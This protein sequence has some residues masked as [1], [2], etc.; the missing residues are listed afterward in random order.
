MQ[1]RPRGRDCAELGNG[2]EMALDCGGGLKRPRVDEQEGQREGVVVEMI[3]V[4]R[5]SV[6]PDELRQRL[7]TH[8]SL[9]GAIPTGALARGWRDLWK[10]RWAHR[11]SVEI[12]L[13]SR[14]APQR[15]LDSLAQEPRPLRR[16]DRFSL[17]VNIC[18][19]RSTDLRRFLDYAAECRVEELHVE[20][21]K[22]SVAEK[23]N[24]HLPL[25]SP[26]LAR[27][28]LRRISISNMYY[29]GAQQFHALE[30]VRLHFVSV[31]EATFCKMM[32][33]CP[34]LRTLDVRGCDCECLF[35]WTWKST[36]L[37]VNLRRI[38]VAECDG[39]AWLNLVPSLLSF[40]YY[41]S[42]F[43]A[44]RPSLFQRTPCSPTFTFA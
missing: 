31:T 19:L 28:S 23:L 43:D 9:K 27:L 14:D 25:S 38:T 2:R 41:G 20:T 35:P 16:L 36:F 30:V 1:E 15:E 6:L 32:A 22:S 24:F 21:R 10:S 44:P 17:I 11:S 4:D 5:I 3:P 29:K 18:K 42:F 12:H 37:P 33:L 34:N 13:H 40:F 39:K 8:L 7:L 26:L